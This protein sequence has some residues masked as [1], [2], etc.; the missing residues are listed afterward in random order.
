MAKLR[1]TQV[2]SAICNQDRVRKV[3]T[4]GLGLG[5]IGSSVML[6]DNPYTR[7]MVAKVAH[8]VRVEAVEE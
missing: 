3:L 6:P 7:G 2:N 8:I 5:R 4:S 1:I